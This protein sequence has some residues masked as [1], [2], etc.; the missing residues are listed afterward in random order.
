MVAFALCSKNFGKVAG[1]YELIGGGDART[2]TAIKE[3]STI[4]F[5]AIIEFV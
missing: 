1:T 4:L 5:A 2:L 3:Y